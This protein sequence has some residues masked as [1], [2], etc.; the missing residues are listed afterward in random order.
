[1]QRI[2]AGRQQYLV[3]VTFRV[4]APDSALVPEEQAVLEMAAGDLRRRLCMLLD[5]ADSELPDPHQGDCSHETH[6]PPSS[7]LCPSA[8]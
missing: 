6:G 4:V 8:D 5:L 1:M 7:K 2:V 3:S